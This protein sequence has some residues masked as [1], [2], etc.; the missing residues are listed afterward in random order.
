MSII[1][2]TISWQ[3]DTLKKSRVESFI[4]LGNGD[5]TTAL[6]GGYVK[7]KCYDKKCKL[8]EHPLINVVIKSQNGFYLTQTDKNGKFGTGISG[9]PTFGLIIQKE[10]YQTMRI[11]NVI[12]KSDEQYWTIIYLEKG[13]G[14]SD[15]LY[16]QQ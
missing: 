4:Y 16:T 12:G 2:I 13:S 1:L 11:S 15:Y 6:I 9:W 5:T 3:T 10:G 8:K 14:Y 7:E